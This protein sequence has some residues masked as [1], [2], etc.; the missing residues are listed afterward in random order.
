MA[1]YVK[2]ILCIAALGIAAAALAQAVP[3]GTVADVAERTQPFGK[4]CLQGE[5]CGGEDAAAEATAAHAVGT[6]MSGSEVYGTYCRACHETGLNDA[7]VLGDAEA[8]APRL[9]KGKDVLLET[10]KTGLNVMPPMGLCMA[11]SD[12]ELRAAIDYL[13]DTAPQTDEAP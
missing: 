11:C 3:A 8:W 4:L 13:I 9:S 1:E 12:D 10:T 2:R 7:P 5:E 6:G